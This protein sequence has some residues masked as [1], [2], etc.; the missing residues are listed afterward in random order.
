MREQ[1]DAEGITS[2]AIPRVGAGHGGLSWKGPC[3]HRS[4][5]RGLAW[6]TDRLRGDRGGRVGWRLRAAGRATPDLNLVQRC[7][8]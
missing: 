8:V 3:D 4:H 7:G 1:A 2:I 6:D 5:L